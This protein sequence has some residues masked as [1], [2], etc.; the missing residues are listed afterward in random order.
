MASYKLLLA[1]ALLA[2]A[3][4]TSIGGTTTYCDVQKASEILA[5]WIEETD[6]TASDLADISS[7]S[8]DSADIDDYDCGDLPD[9]YRDYLKCIQD[10]CEDDEDP[11]SDGMKD[12]VERCGATG[13]LVSLPLYLA[14]AAM[15]LKR[16]YNA[17]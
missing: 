8:V 7:V 12:L 16:V 4:K 2:G 3:L 13:L 6:L 1:V 5:C 14:V 15:T 11:I 17:V 10:E 9:E